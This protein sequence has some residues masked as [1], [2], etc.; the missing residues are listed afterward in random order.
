MTE[1]NFDVLRVICGLLTNVPAVLSFS[2]TCSTLHPVAVER[3]LSMRAVTIHSAESVRDLHNYIFVDEKRRGQHIR[4]ITIPFSDMDPNSSEELV[5]R[6]LAVFESASH[7]RTLSLYVPGSGRHPSLFRHPKVLAAVSNMPRLQELGVVAS[8]G[9]ASELLLSN[10]CR[11]LKTFRHSDMPVCARHRRDSHIPLLR[12]AGSP[13]TSTL[14]EMELTLD[15]LEMAAQG[16]VSFPAVRSVTL[17]NVEDIFLLDMLLTVFPNLDRT[18]IVREAEYIYISHRVAYLRGKNREVAGQKT[19]AQSTKPLDRVAASADI[20]YALGLARPIRHLTLSMRWNDIHEPQ[21]SATTTSSA[22]ALFHEHA[23]T[24]LALVDVRLPHGFSNL[25][26]MLFPEDAVVP[27]VTHLVLDTTYK[28][29][30]IP[31]DSYYP[32]PGVYGT[33]NASWD[34]VLVRTAVPSYCRSSSSRNGTD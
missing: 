10:R 6:L 22:R 16:H 33:T 24:H 34:A 19:L 18:L 2:L 4:A 9:Q 8:A 5:D 21:A 7:V 32:I 1:L 11:A 30:T 13:L 15:L 28:N 20:L 31:Y 25:D 14:E 17:T 27:R 29:T 23:P 12:L 3:R 26:S